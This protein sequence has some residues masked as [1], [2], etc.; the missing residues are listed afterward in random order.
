MRRLPFTHT[1]RQEKE[2]ERE[3]FTTTPRSVS[4]NI[5]QCIQ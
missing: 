1:F 3:D 2:R 4:L 5:F